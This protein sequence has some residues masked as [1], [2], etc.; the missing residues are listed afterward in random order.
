MLAFLPDPHNSKQKAQ[1]ALSET[2][3]AEHIYFP[4]SLT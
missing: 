4:Q 2:E 1:A 3:K